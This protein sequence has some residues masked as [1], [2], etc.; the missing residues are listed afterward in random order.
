MN[1][2]RQEHT[3]GPW[4]YDKEENIIISKDWCIGGLAHIYRESTLANGYLIAAAPDLLG[5]CFRAAAYI[6]ENNGSL[7]AVQ[8]CDSLKYLQNALK[9]AR[10]GK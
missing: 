10:G 9:K 2:E 4:E 3:P 6:K 1:I 8:Y 5:A 7:S